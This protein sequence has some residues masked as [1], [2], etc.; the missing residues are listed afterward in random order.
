[1]MGFWIFMALMVA[2]LP[3]CMIYFG[4]RFMATPPEE[5]NSLYGYR[6]YRSMKN[7]DT[8]QFAHQYFGRIWYRW[9][10]WALPVSLLLMLF[11]IGKGDD[12]IGLAGCILLGIQ[13]IPLIIPIFLTEIALRQ[14]FDKDGNRI[15]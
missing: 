7:A 13:M 14:H 11:F 6:T 3:L 5:I 10:L 9:G 1:M 15:S 4:R 8:W 12:I 2:L